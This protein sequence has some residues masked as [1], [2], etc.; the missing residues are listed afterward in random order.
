[1]YG[2][3]VDLTF[4]LGIETSGGGWIML[5]DVIDLAIAGAV[6]GGKPDDFQ[7]SALAGLGKPFGS[8]C[9]AFSLYLF[10]RHPLGVGIVSLP[11]RLVYLGT[12]P[13]VVCGGFVSAALAFG[14]VR[15]PA[16]F[17]RCLLRRP[18]GSV[19][20]DLARA[21]RMQDGDC[22]PWIAKASGGF[23]SGGGEGDLSTA[24]G[25]GGYEEL[26]ARGL[27]RNGTDAAGLKGATE[28]V[29]GHRVH[30]MPAGYLSDIVMQISINIKMASF[31]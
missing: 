9:G 10:V 2:Q 11:Q 26:A 8:S 5:G 27:H 23:P 12:E 20:L 17:E 19:H 4:N 21:Q 13:G 1:V 6:S 31:E 28:L 16:A 7:S 14:G 22:L 30:W 18:I 15:A 29:E 3:H 25:F 24:A